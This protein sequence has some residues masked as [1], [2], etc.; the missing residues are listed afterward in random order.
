[1]LCLY[2]VSRKVP[3]ATDGVAAAGSRIS[4]F[5]EVP[6]DAEGATLGGNDSGR[7]FRFLPR[8][9][10]CLRVGVGLAVTT[11]VLLGWVIAVAVAD[12]VAAG[13]GEVVTTG[14]DETG[15]GVGCG[16]GVTVATESDGGVPVG[17]G[18]GFGVADRAGVTTIVGVGDGVAVGLTIGFALEVSALFIAVKLT[19][20]GVPATPLPSFS[21]YGMAVRVCPPT[22]GLQA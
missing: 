10:F 3:A 8:I 2:S 14:T 5:V 15:V 18:D 11:G 19:L 17:C 12:G 6:G 20:S 9:R 4:E 13:L 1:M 16:S 22:V 21:L 7:N